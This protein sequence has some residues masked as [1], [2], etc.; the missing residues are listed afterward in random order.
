MK[1]PCAGDG[2]AATGAPAT[3]RARFL[4]RVRGAR[5]GTVSRVSNA[6]RKLINRSGAGV[7]QNCSAVPSLATKQSLA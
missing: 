4:R 2:C 1:D 6:T 7:A 5:R 3:D